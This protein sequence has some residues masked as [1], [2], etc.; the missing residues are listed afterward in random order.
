LPAVTGKEAITAAISRLRA[1]TARPR[2]DQ[3]ANL[4]LSE[5]RALYEPHLFALSE[6]FGLA[7][8][9]WGASPEATDNWQASEW[10]QNAGAFRRIA[11]RPGVRRHF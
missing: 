4:K 3:E 11:S 2:A 10:S 8:P 7:L 1:S 6:Y 5:L 9:P